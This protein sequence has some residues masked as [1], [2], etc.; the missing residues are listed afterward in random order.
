MVYI[1]FHSYSL[2]H[3]YFFSNFLSHFFTRFFYTTWNVLS[4]IL[5]KPGSLYSP[6]LLNE[7]IYWKIY[8]TL[9]QEPYSLAARLVVMKM[10]DFKSEPLHKCIHHDHDLIFNPRNVINLQSSIVIQITLRNNSLRL[11]YL[12]KLFLDK[13]FY[14]ARF[15]FALKIWI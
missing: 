10:I 1:Y 5:C 7:H 6:C 9:S 15:K 4:F 8:S 11:L 12:N 2:L 14:L 13:Y 3:V